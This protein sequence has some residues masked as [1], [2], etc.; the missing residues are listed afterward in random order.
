MTIGDVFSVVAGIFGSFLT[1]WAAVVAAGLL[2]PGPTERARVSL[3]EPKR[4]VGRGLAVAATLGFLSIV[5][6][7]NPFPLVKGLGMIL[8]FW[9]L[10]VSVLGTAGV[11]SAVGRRIQD[12]DPGMA[13]Y[14][15]TVR[16]A[17]FVVGGTLL[18]ILGWFA[19]G[20][21]LFIASLGAGWQALVPSIRRREA[22]EVA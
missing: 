15:A 12:L 17:A 11:A 8:L 13:A 21:V 19:F 14:P 16:G 18:P 3:E 7:A 1:L 22:S 10:A 6:S 4:A 2:F 20:P 9:L 5:M